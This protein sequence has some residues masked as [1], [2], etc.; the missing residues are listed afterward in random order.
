MMKFVFVCLIGG[1]AV[2]STQASTFSLPANGETIG[3]YQTVTMK[4]G[5]TLLQ[6]AQL[7]D[8]G[9]YEIANANPELKLHAPQEAGIE[10][11]IPSR[12]QLPPGPREGIVLNLAEMRM[13][14]FHP[15]ESMVSTYPV[16]I[17]KKGWPTPE[18]AT[19]ITAKEYNPSWRPTPSIRREAARRGN[20]LPPVVPPGPHNPLGRYAIRL[21]ISSILIHATTQPASIGLHSSHGCIRMYSRNIEELFKQVPIGT[22]VRI[23][24]QPKN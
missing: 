21:G 15:D 16:G 6:L 19:Q 23:I 5:E 4:Q 11:I 17:G 3:N 24:H 7:F 9:V 22:N 1:I 14:Y 13:Y 8:I 18:G 2:E 20:T 10:A 12:Y